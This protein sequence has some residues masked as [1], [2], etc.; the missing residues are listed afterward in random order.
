VENQ[1]ELDPIFFKSDKSYF[2]A[3][4]PRT[5]ITNW[6]K[7]TWIRNI[8]DYTLSTSEA[9]MMLPVDIIQALT[10]WLVVHWLENK[11]ADDWIINN[12]EARRQMKRDEALDS[13]INDLDEGCWTN[14]YP[15]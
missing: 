6:I 2:I 11:G 1:S 3:P 14:E 12:A 15:E 10:Y 4:A 7:L 5:A 13:V 8:P 9:D